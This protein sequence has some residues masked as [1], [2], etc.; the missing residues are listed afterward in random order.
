MESGLAAGFATP[1][2]EII[3]FFV[4][5]ATALMMWIGTSIRRSRRE[6]EEQIAEAESRYQELAASQGL[7]TAERDLLDRMTGYVEDPRKK[8]LLLQDHRLFNQVAAEML[9]DDAASQPNISTLRM[10]LGFTGSPTGLV[11]RATGEIPTGAEILVRRNKQEPVPAHVTHHEASSLHVKLTETKDTA[12]FTAGNPV[13]I[14]YRNEAGIFY[15]DSTVF[16]RRD[17]ILELNHSEKGNHIQRRGHFRRS[18]RL[19]VTITPRDDPDASI[20]SEFSELGGNGGTLLNPDKRFGA[21][22]E[23]MLTFYP[24][25]DAV[26]TVFARVIRTS[27]EDELL[28]VRFYNLPERE[29]DQIY[30]FLFST[31]GS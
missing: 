15:F 19:P 7:S 26:L 25:R 2:I 17:D 14:I 18:I 1:V 20:P 12:H 21:D 24:D 29:R 28:H 13:Q 3:I 9:A 23:L 27:R 10:S 5:L 11:P 22:D 4:I 16:S 30:R 8:Y 31:T 6:R